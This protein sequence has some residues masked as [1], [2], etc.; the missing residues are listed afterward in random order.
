MRAG[1]G[2]VAASA[3]TVIVVMLL[4][5]M[6][7]SSGVYSSGPSPSPMS[8]T[9]LPFLSHADYLGPA[10]QLQLIAIAFC[11]RL[12]VTGLTSY[13]RSTDDPG[14]PNYHRYLTHPDILSQYGPSASVVNEVINWTSAEGFGSPSLQFGD[15]LTVNTTVGQVEAALKIPLNLY[16]YRGEVFYANPSDPSLPLGISLALTNIGGLNDYVGP[17]KGTATIGGGLAMVP[18]DILS[19][20]DFNPMFQ[21]GV[22]AS[23][24]TIAIIGWPGNGIY[25]SDVKGFWNKY[26]SQAG[27]IKQVVVGGGS[28]PPVDTSYASGSEEMTLDAEWA[29]V[30]GQKANVTVVTSN[31]ASP[32]SY[33][34]AWETQWEAELNYIVTYIKPS[35][36]SASIGQFID[37]LPKAA[38]DNIHALLASAAG[39][40]TLVVGYSGDLGYENQGNGIP[41]PAADPFSLSAGGLYDNLNSSTPGITSQRGWSL[42]DMNASTAS[43]GGPVT[44]YSQPTSQSMETI[45]APSNLYRDVPDISMPAAPYLSVFFNGNLIKDAGTSFAAPM[46]A[47][48]MA[49]VFQ[50]VARI[51]TVVNGMYD[52]GYGTSYGYKAYNDIGTG[53]NGQPA[54]AG[55]D[56]VTGIGAPDAWN[57]ARDIHNYYSYY[58]SM[59]TFPTSGGGT[60]SPSSGWYVAGQSVTI[61]A[62]PNTAA[63]YSFAGWTGSGTGNYTGSNNPDT[64]TMSSNIGEMASFQQGGGGSPGCVLQGT[65]ITLANRTQIPVQNLKAGDSVL[66]YDTKIGKLTTATVSSNTAIQVN[67]VLDINNGLFYASGLQDQPIY[68]RMQNG[69][70]RALFLGQLAVGMKLFEPVSGTWASVTRIQILTGSYV[71]YDVRTTDGGPYIADS[72][73]PSPK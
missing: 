29:G 9:V 49:D 3:V 46:M 40:G 19:Y 18:A 70:Q 65:L 71:V 4:A 38:R 15:E 57:L 37:Q 44:Y 32:C 6:S 67:Q 59:A 42:G 51:P 26:L 30:T 39:E 53:N 2:R 25:T 56:Y 41:E 23:H 33:T 47:G 28:P 16:S 34:G 17:A 22:S 50:Y 5:G 27:T 73:M 68:A 69:T 31:C 66:S 1:E 52:L 20:Y 36:V 60:V 55:W 10:D 64:I 24:Q 8:S 14:S 35:V 11:L 43:G 13:V 72:F 61:H 21:A 58:L 48:L 45:K 12:D 62:Y 7:T 54:G 63:G